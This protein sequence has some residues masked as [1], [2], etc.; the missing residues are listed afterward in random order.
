[1]LKRID[2]GVQVYDFYGCDT[3]SL[4]EERNELKEEGKANAKKKQANSK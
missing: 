3:W 4:F 1:L 2:W